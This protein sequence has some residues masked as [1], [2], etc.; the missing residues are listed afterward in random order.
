VSLW[1]WGGGLSY[2][3]PVVAE[4]AATVTSIQ[5]PV[6]TGKDGM[7]YAASGIHSSQAQFVWTPAE[8]SY[9]GALVSCI[10]MLSWNTY[11]TSH[12]GLK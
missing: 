11:L 4:V 5:S 8:L 12:T 9:I 10:S 6:A 3:H 1:S 2:I 7:L